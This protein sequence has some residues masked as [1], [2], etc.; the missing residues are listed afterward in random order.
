MINTNGDSAILGNRGRVVLEKL[1]SRVGKNDVQVWREDDN[2]WILKRD[3]A[4]FHDV[5]YAMIP[6]AK[7][8]DDVEKWAE[9]ERVVGSKDKKIKAYF[10][11]T[12]II[13]T[14]R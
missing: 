7:A 8:E 11:A 1:P 9:I 14:K 13:A 6:W 10:P 4:W 5:Y 12:Q 2:E 3:L